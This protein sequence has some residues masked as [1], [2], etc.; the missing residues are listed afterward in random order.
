[1]ACL[2]RFDLTN[3]AFALA[4]LAARAPAQDAPK[5][6]PA[7]AKPG[8]ES[9]APKNTLFFIG[10]DNLDLLRADCAASPWGRLCADP[11]NEA[12]RKSF[13][14]LL[15]KLGAA[16]EKEMG[17]DVVEAIERVTGRVGIA[18]FGELGPTGHDF[19]F[20][21]GME[22][23]EHV[24]ELRALAQKA[25]DHANEQGKLVLKTET[26][27]DVEVT[28]AVPKDPESHDP[29]LRIG[30]AGPVLLVDGA[31]GSFRDKSNF[32]N[33]VAALK[34]E[35]KESLASLSSFKESRAARAGGVKF[36]FDTGATV[37]ARFAAAKAAKKEGEA[38]DAPDAESD[39]G[40]YGAKMSAAL[41]FDELGPLSARVD[42]NAT[43][44]RVE[45]LQAWGGK[46]G[47]AQLLTGWLSGSDVSLLQVIPA[48]AEH[49]LAVH[50]DFAKGMA[51]SAAIEKAVTGVDV[52]PD[53]SAPADPNAPPDADA[54]LDPKRDFMDH[55][56]GRIAFYIANVDP[57][58]A[59]PMLGTSKP[60]GL[61]LALGVKSAEPLRASLEKFLRSMG[62]HAARKKS[63]FQGFQVF[64][65]PVT[66]LTIHYAVLDDVALISTSLTMLQDVLRRKSDKELKNLAGD[67][68]FKR[69]FEAL[70]PGSSLVLWS[71]ADPSVFSSIGGPLAA[72]DEKEG[73]ADGAAK[74]LDASM[75]EGFLDFM[76][77]LGTVDPAVAAKHLP[78]GSVV[79]IGANAGG[80]HLEGVSR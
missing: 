80:I 41:G 6:A 51:A 71:R 3:V 30:A 23:Q 8:F 55:L 60:R 32:Q 17:I 61:C 9:F 58:E 18:S 53:G 78:A 29:D 24:A 22:S 79:G 33:A 67:A 63:E 2:D 35:G 45:A 38:A 28:L 52:P 40:G 49:A 48:E 64:T 7:P 57:S 1:M 50:V 11:T 25:L 10:V 12:L 65:V 26:E 39:D 42:V 34:G 36:W 56:D 62:L 69:E 19:A 4:L 59:A 20:T 73:G 54:P 75:K 16:T 37:R 76:R 66:P 15:T 31:A 46:G 21:W 13:A 70:T 77:A 5:P 43:E 74:S 47:L 27:G 44:M 14:S 72:L 68:S